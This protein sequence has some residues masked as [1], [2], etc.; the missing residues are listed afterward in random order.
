VLN[1][2]SL[3][4]Y[5]NKL[6]HFTYIIL[7]TILLIN[8]WSTILSQVHEILPHIF[9]IIGKYLFLSFLSTI[10]YLLQ[11]W[12][13][14]HDKRTWV[15]MSSSLETPR[16]AIDRWFYPGTPVFSNNKNW[17]P[18]YSWNIIESGVIITINQTVW[19]VQENTRSVVSKQKITHY[20]CFRILICI[21]RNKN[22]SIH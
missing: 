14:N 9:R 1:T 16:L 3:T 8:L 10:V 11:D 20:C 18:L 4:L 22:M 21:E 17:P 2:I 12:R 6:I 7:Y 13:I 15:T 19:N 5:C